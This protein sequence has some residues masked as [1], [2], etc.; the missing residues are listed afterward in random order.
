M[1]G[2]LAG[3][4]VAPERL[5]DQLVGQDQAGLADIADRQAGNRLLVRSGVRNTQNGDIAMNFFECASS[6]GRA[7][8]ITRSDGFG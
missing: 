2:R 6:E 3:R 4:L 8:A 7:L 5:A 1:T